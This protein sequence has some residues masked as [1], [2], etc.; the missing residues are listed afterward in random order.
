MVDGRFILD[1]EACFVFILLT[2]EK[3]LYNNST[4]LDYVCANF[5]YFV[6]Y[7]AGLP[8]YPRTDSLI[9]SE[10]CFLIIFCC[11]WKYAKKFLYIIFESL[12]N[13]I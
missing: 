10:K 11:Y 12:V 1:I 5:Q 3:E 6:K 8:K 2:M 4:K 9:T 13:H 7:T